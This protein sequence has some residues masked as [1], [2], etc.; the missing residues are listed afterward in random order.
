MKKKVFFMLTAIFCMFVC[1]T[2]C[3]SNDDEFPKWEL[4]TQ[5]SL[6]NTDW[7]SLA[8]KSGIIGFRG[9]NIVYRTTNTLGGYRPKH[10][11]TF[12]VQGDKIVFMLD[13]DTKERT[14]TAKFYYDTKYS[15]KRLQLSIDEDI[16]DEFPYGECLLVHDVSEYL[17]D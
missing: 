9:N 3:S 7:L 10:I 12:K 8:G 1:V 5:E 14:V 15:E 13:G 17:F 11:G 4:T 16:Y 6:N 2:S